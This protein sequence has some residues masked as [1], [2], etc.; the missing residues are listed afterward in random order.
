[1]RTWP[2]LLALALSLAPHA[3]ADDADGDDTQSSETDS[4]S[5][6]P[7]VQV[8][9][10]GALRF[11]GCP[12]LDADL[13]DRLQRYQALRS[14]GFRGFVGGPDEGVFIA[15]RFA[16]VA[17]T[18]QVRMPMGARTQLTFGE[19]PIRAIMPHPHD[20]D[21]VLLMSDLGGNEAYQFELL[22]PS[23]SERT[24]LTDGESRHGGITWS[25]DPSRPTAVLYT[26]TARNGKDYDIYR[27]DVTEPGQAERIFEGEGYAW[28]ADWD[29]ASD[30]IIV[31]RYISS[32][33]SRLYTLEDG[34]LRPLTPEGEVSAFG[35]VLSPDASTAYVVSDHE[36]QFKSLYAVDVAS[37]AMQA[38][39]VDVDWD[40]DD[41]TLSADGRT[42]AFTVNERGWSNLYLLDLKKGRVRTSSA[43]PDGMVGRIQFDP[44][45]PRTLGMSISGADKPSDAWT[46]DIKKDRATRWTRSETAGLAPSDFVAPQPLTWK[47]FDG[48]ELDGFW[49][50]PEGPG[51]FP[52]VVSIHGGPEGQSRPY[53]SST[54]QVLV[55]QGIAVVVPNVRG[56]RGYGKDFI[57]LDNGFKRED[58]VKDIGTLL[59][60]IDEQPDLDADRVAVRGGSYGGYMVLASLF[61]YSDRLV[62]GIDVVGIS[63]FVT[64]LENT[65]AYRRDLRRVEY[66][67]ERDPKMREHLL[68]IS[69]TSHVDELVDPLLVIHGANDPRVPVSEAEQIVQAVRNND[70][71]VCYL[72]AENEGHG[73]RKKD[74][75]EVSQ[76]LSVQFL[77]RL[78]VE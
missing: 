6:A 40:V 17:Q 12:E 25:D 49:Y 1:M 48:L 21:M 34:S 35:G 61:H 15:T 63:N 42:L 24:L 36:G 18:H 68:A 19:E 60:W 76:V 58:S 50:R 56:S 62:G 54:Y 66:G 55:Q 52:V 51:P 32:T 26:G 74:N 71:E 44:Q 59:D 20:P 7:Q 4:D 22:R 2:A 10:V 23:T 33:Q 77:T 64:F 13:A 72:R 46:L 39:P 3:L 8:R 70:Q 53:L 29:A 45:D 16:D 67:D 65:K 73:F 5:E 11:E 69:P 78:L 47:S 38:L 41:V 31:G 9:E 14:A 75:R 30:T 57:K 27:A 37:G 43:L 28:V